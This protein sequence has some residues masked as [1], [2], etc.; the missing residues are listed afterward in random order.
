MM[1]LQQQQQSELCAAA[2]AVLGSWE[3]F[4]VADFSRHLVAAFNSDVACVFPVFIHG[5]LGGMGGV[6]LVSVCVRTVQVLAFV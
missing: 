3:S 6:T 4:R 5:G 2:A 1:V